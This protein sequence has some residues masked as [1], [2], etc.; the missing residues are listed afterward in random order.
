MKVDPISKKYISVISSK[1]NFCLSSSKIASVSNNLAFG[2]KKVNSNTQKI[3][4][5][6]TANAKT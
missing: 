1:K 5:L 4:Y 3:K 2:Q 6:V